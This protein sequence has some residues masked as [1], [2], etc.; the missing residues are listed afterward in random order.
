MPSSTC[1][2]FGET[3]NSTTIKC[4]TI[5]IALLQIG[6]CASIIVM[7]CVIIKENKKS[8]AVKAQNRKEKDRNKYLLF[9]A[10]LVSGTNI[11]CWLPSSAVYFTSVIMKNYPLTLLT[12]NAVLINPINSVINP[13]VFYFM[14]LFKSIFQ[15]K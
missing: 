14:P 12:W 4:L 9:Q 3:L 13:T 8:A 10:L 5:F 2:L 1:L 7:Y 6:V 11:M 15:R